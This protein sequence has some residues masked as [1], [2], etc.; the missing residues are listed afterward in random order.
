[1]RQNFV[2]SILL[3][4]QEVLFEKVKED[5]V[6]INGTYSLDEVRQKYDNC[7]EDIV[8]GQ[9]VRTGRD[10]KMPVKAMIVVKEDDVFE[11]RDCLLFDSQTE[12]KHHD[13]MKAR[14]NHEEARK[15]AMRCRPYAICRADEIITI[16]APTATPA[17]KRGRPKKTE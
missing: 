13:E 16:I 5:P 8:I 6:V 14:D 11:D 3:N 10:V 17:K 7:L 2:D 15:L 9:V 12:A 4:P 1:M